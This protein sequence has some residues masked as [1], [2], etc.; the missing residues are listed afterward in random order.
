MIDV[1]NLYM[2]VVYVASAIS[3]FVVVSVVCLCK[4]DG[5]NLVRKTLRKKYKWAALGILVVAGSFGA[6]IATNFQ[7]FWT[8]FHYVFFTNDLWMLDPKVSIMINMFPLNFFFAMCRQILICFVIWCLVV[9]LAV[10]DFGNRPKWLKG[11]RQYKD[12]I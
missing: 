8:N 6:V 5:I 11:K 9:R 10:A 7:W 12:V 3:A 1:V 2:G 4:K